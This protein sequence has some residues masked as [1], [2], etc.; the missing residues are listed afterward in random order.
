MLRGVVSRAAVVEKVAALTH[1]R[2]GWI[3]VAALFALYVIWGSTYLAI[4]I[5]V[6]EVP[7]FLFA[8]TRF[9]VAGGLLYGF[10]RL[11]GVAAP[12]RANWGA[13]GLI[14]FLLLALGNGGVSY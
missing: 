9:L 5:V 3:D 14:G 2:M 11:R 10:L 12:T 1:R 4:R 6:V 8:G 7:P 13:A